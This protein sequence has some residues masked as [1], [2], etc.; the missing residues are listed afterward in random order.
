MRRRDAQ[1]EAPLK[2]EE[3]QGEDEADWSGTDSVKGVNCGTGGGSEAVSGYGASV[4]PF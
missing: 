4:M 1:E 3:G 2:A